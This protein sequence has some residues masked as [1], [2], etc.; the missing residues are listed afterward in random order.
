LRRR[1]ISRLQVLAELLE[2]G[3]KLLHPALYGGLNVVTA[4]SAGNG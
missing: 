4:K 2:F 1:D 3:L